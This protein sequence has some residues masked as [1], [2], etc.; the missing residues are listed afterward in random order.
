MTEPGFAVVFIPGICTSAERSS[1]VKAWDLWLG[2]DVC[3]AYSSLPVGVREYGDKASV[4][5]GMPTMIADARS[6][7]PGALA[8]HSLDTD[9]HVIALLG[10]QT[11]RDDG[12]DPAAA[13]AHE[14][15]EAFRNPYVNKWVDMPDGL[16]SMSQ[17]LCDPVQ[18]LMYQ[19]NGVNMSNFVLPDYWNPDAVLGVDK[20]DYMGA[21]TLPFTRTPGGYFVKRR[22]ATGEIQE[23]GVR[24]KH[25]RHAHGRVS[26][27]VAGHRAPGV[28]L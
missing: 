15:G 22:H 1:W 17:E 23:I 4:P 8:Y 5:A 19:V 2:R 6:D 10:V 18:D 28:V 25:K 3:A 7:V 20:L 11:C 27:I 12:A 24:P 21:L 16:W 13:G 14:L 26:R 9:G